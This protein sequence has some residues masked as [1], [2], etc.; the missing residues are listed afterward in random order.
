[1][2]QDPGL[3]LV[4]DDDSSMRQLLA[5]M[6][7]GAGHQVVQAS[8]GN[9]AIAYARQH[10]VSLLITDLVM[11]EPEGIET[12]QRFVQEFPLIPIIAMSAESDYLPAAQ[13]LGARGVLKKPFTRADLQQA[14]RTVI[15]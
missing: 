7:E 5:A 9:A 12:I 10:V 15:G 14:I 8:D 2:K 6:L 3:I 13:A 4:L 1:M 11:P